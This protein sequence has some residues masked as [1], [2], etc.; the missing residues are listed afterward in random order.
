ML[1]VSGLRT[2]VFAGPF[3]MKTTSHDISNISSIKSE[4]DD[5][6]VSG[7]IED[8]HETSADEKDEDDWYGS[9]VESIKTDDSDVSKSL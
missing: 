1:A 9:K 4:G 5:L 8:G 7:S 3:E 2:H 6:D